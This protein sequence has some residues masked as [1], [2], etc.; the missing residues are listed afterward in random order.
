MKVRKA[1][2]EMTG[3][4]VLKDSREEMEL[5]ASRALKATWGLRDWTVPRDPMDSK[6]IKAGRE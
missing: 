6:E 5:K 4:T 3:Q 2:K 1:S